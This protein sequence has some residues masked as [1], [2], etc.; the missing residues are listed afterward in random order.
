MLFPPAQIIS[1]IV[2][3]SCLVGKDLFKIAVNE[4]ANSV[5]FG[6]LFFE[7][8]LFPHRNFCFLSP[9]FCLCLFDKCCRNNRM[10][11]ESD[12]N[13]KMGFP[14]FAF[15]FLDRCQNSPCIKPFLCPILGQNFAYFDLLVHHKCTMSE[16]R[17]LHL[18]HKSLSINMARDRIEL[19]TQ[20]F[21]VL[22][23]PSASYPRSPIITQHDLSYERKWIFFQE[24]LS[25]QI[26]QSLVSVICYSGYIPDKIGSR[27]R[28]KSFL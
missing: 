23:S 13:A 8:A 27:I 3:I 22:K 5:L 20:G 11:F 25:I 7:E 28:L 24:R 18:I 1:I 14:V 6:T 4:V 2:C 21:S 9:L 17:D 10:A 26:K 16:N 12:I 19:S 15:S